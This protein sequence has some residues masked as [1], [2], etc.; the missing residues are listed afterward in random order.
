MSDGISIDWS[1]TEATF[2]QALREMARLTELPLK[3]V[4][5]AEAGSILKF[6][7]GET[8]VA[9]PE[10]VP[11]RAR[12]RLIRELGFNGRAGG[13]AIQISSGIR[14]P[15]VGGQITAMSTGPRSSRKRRIAYFAS[16]DQS[17]EYTGSPSK[18]HWKR[19]D[20]VD[21][22]EARADYSRSAAQWISRAMKSIG[23][24]RQSWIQIADSIG[25][26]LESVPGGRL[27][28]AGIAKARAAI[29][30]DGQ[31][32]INGRSREVDSAESYF[33]DL[34]NVYP[35]NSRL[36]MPRILLQAIRNRQSHFERLLNKGVFDSMQ[37][38]AQQ[39]PGF[40]VNRG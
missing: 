9:D 12:Q 37:A 17:V 16:V 39:F 20:W 23:L 22:Q 35:A 38:V 2:G 40:Y 21:I 34:I 8:K 26:R 11:S 33:V 3:T 4:V 1:Q 18:F 32:H 14:K 31:R 5:R 6:C 10:K 27:S 29:A 19:S 30:S 15:T 25:I 7:A 28:A 36:G 13:T 24:A